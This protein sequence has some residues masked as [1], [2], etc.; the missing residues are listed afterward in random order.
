VPI[1]AH[2]LIS[3]H[4]LN[5]YVKRGLKGSRFRVQVGSGFRVQGSG[6]RVQVQGKFRFQGSTLNKG[7]GFK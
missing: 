4:I 7:S 1:Q 6:F 3:W 5:K 2:G